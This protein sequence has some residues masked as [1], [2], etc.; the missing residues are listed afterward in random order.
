MR[1]R[2][3]LRPHTTAWRRS[4]GCLDEVVVRREDAH[5]SNLNRKRRNADVHGMQMIPIHARNG[6]RRILG[7][8]IEL[9][10]KVR[11]EPGIVALEVLHI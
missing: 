6:P 9:S 5:Y 1:D 4:E 7:P 2:N 10:K 3:T 11:Y 8:Q